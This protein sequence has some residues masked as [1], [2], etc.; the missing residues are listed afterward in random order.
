MQPGSGQSVYRR[1]RTPL[2]LPLTELARQ[3]VGE[4]PLSPA[5]RATVNL[6]LP[7]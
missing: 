3:T 4:V 2:P 7:E 6:A 1:S 5:Y